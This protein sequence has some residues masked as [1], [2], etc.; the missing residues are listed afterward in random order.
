M[1]TIQ[2]IIMQLIIYIYIYFF[3]FI[4]KLYDFCFFLQPYK[5]SCTTTREKY[6]AILYLTNLC[7]CFSSG[8]LLCLHLLDMLCKRY[9]CIIHTIYISYFDCW[10][11]DLL[12][13]TQKK[14]IR[15]DWLKIFT[16]SNM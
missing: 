16:M 6:Y 9:I 15:E 13:N 11:E 14:R 8:C 10:G 1:T 12:N 4:F 2:I 7:R 5:I 3:P